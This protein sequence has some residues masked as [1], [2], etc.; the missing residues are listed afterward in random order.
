MSRMFVHVRL[1]VV[2]A[3]ARLMRVALLL[4]FDIVLAVLLGLMVTT[5]DYGRKYN[6]SCTRCREAD[7]FL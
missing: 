5:L 4:L 2:D 7:V 6:L 3:R 1:C